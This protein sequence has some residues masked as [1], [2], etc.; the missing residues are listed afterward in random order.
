MSL[1]ANV[2]HLVFKAVYDCCY[3]I[4]NMPDLVSGHVLWGVIIM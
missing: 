3:P 1:I 2:C 4:Q